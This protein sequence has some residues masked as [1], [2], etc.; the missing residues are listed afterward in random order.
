MH[1][2]ANY[3]GAN[4]AVK[5]F[6]CSAQNNFLSFKT[7]CYLDLSQ[8]ISTRSPDFVAPQVKKPPEQA[9]W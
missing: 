6:L 8:D 3:R 7:I 4:E 1:H 5:K 9:A 2:G